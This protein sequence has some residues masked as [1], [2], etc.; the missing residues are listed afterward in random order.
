MAIKLRLRPRVKRN[1]QPLPST[2]R[3]S[4][5]QQPGIRRASLACEPKGLFRHV[6]VVFHWMA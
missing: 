2:T 4:V 3:G 6:L 5:T 1:T